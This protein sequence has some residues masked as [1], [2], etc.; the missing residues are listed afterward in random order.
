MLFK[1]NRWKINKGAMIV[2]KGK[3]VGTLYLLSTQVDH[4]VSL[5]AERNEKTTLWHH[6]LRHLS[7]SGMRI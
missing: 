6:M 4:V 7:V 3:R 5:A 1:E 2:M